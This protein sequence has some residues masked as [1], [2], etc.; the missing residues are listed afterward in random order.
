M[1]FRLSW[2]LAELRNNTRE[3]NELGGG[4][5]RNQ[6]PCTVACGGCLVQAHWPLLLKL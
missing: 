1:F 6:C 4:E 3:V 2:L 5:E